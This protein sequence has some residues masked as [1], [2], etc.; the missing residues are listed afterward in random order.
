MA[1]CIYYVPMSRTLRRLAPFIAAAV[2]LSPLLREPRDDT[3]PLSTYPMFATDRGAIMSIDT[4]VTIDPTGGTDHLSPKQISGTDEI[5]S[6]AVVVS[7][8]VRNGDAELLC[9][10]IADRLDN[11]DLTVQIRTEVVDTAAL[12]DHNARPISIEVVSECRSG[13]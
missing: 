3:Y 2:I 11:P 8:A 9:I 12:V 1:Y 6:A 10:D 7:R 4:A 13:Q 5:V